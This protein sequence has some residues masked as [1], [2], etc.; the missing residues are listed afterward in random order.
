[1]EGTTKCVKTVYIRISNAYPYTIN[2]HEPQHYFCASQLLKNVKAI[3]E[4]RTFRFNPEELSAYLQQ[5]NFV[6][7]EDSGASDY[8]DKNLPGR[9]EKGYE[10]YRVTFAIKN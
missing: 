5:Y 6:L 1:M 9:P 8:R 7:P 4:R 2:L 3:D 10:F